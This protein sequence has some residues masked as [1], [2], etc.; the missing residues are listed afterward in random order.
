M[1]LSLCAKVPNWDFLGLRTDWLHV[2]ISSSSAQLRNLE[3]L[4]LQ[5]DIPRVLKSRRGWNGERQIQTFQW[6][7]SGRVVVFDAKLKG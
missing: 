7:E 6:A 1:A 4:R 2:F 3:T 5:K